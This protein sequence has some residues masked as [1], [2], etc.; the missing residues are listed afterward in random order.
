MNQNELSL[1][2]S[3]IIYGIFIYPIHIPLLAL[4]I[5]IPHATWG[6]PSWKDWKQDSHLPQP[7]LHCRFHKNLKNTRFSLTQHSFLLSYPIST[8]KS[9]P[10]QLFTLWLCDYCYLFLDHYFYDLRSI[11][12]GP[13]DAVLTLLH[14]VPP[15]S[16]TSPS[17]FIFYVTPSCS[18]HYVIRMFSSLVPIWVSELTHLIHQFI[19]GWANL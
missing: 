13:F 5:R 1:V 2:K 14:V 3:R 16:S 17:H 7:Q 19:V 10:R 18:F 15:F 4:H 9:S 8:S 6:W 12:F 11:K